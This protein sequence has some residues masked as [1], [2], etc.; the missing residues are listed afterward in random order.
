MNLAALANRAGTGG[1]AVANLRAAR[2]LGGLRG[3]SPRRQA[4]RR[5]PEAAGWGASRIGSLRRRV[6]RR[7]PEA[8]GWGASRAG[9]PRRPVVQRHPEAV[10]WGAPHAAVGLSGRPRDLAVRGQ[11]VGIAGPVPA[12]PAGLGRTK[13]RHSGPLSVCEREKGGRVFFHFFTYSPK[14]AKLANLLTIGMYVVA[15]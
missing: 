12:G 10:G 1:A 6:A 5:H 2:Q 4:A 13:Q 15:R 3:D 11:E 14:L 8:V 7:H 9:G